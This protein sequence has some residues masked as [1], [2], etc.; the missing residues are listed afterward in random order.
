LEAAL[1]VGVSAAPRAGSRQ[2]GSDREEGPGLAE[3]ASIDV[4]GLKITPLTVEQLVRLI[5]DQIAAGLRCV[6]ANQN[7]HGAYLYFRDAAFRDLHARAFVHIDGMPIVWLARLAG[8]PLTRAHRLTYLDL[9]RSLLAAAAARRWTL[10]YL[11]GE[12][13]VLELGL[14]RLRQAHPGLIVAGHHGFFDQRPASSESL[15]VVARINA[16]RPNL[17]VI[18]MGMPRQE[19]WLLD[20]VERLDANCILLAGAYLDYIAGRQATPPRWL[21]PIGLE[22]LYRLLA[23]PRR[24]WR[25]YLLEPWVLLWYLSR[26]RLR[27]RVRR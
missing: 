5:A 17:L 11:G 4:F 18:G 19:H 1:D 3:T 6:I 10:F 14:E 12:P 23:D 9:M 15:A 26:H 24:L 22:W 16:A 2:R 7:L 13:M 27:G 8:Y 20:H 21:G 25:R